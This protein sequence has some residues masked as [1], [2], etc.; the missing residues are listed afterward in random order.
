M[1]IIIDA[2]VYLALSALAFAVVA[3]LHRAVLGPVRNHAERVLFWSVWTAVSVLFAGAYHVAKGDLLF[4]RMLE[5][6]AL[7]IAFVVSIG[8]TIGATAVLSRRK[9]YDPMTDPAFLAEIE[10]RRRQR[11]ERWQAAI[12][13][14][15][16]TEIEHTDRR[17]LR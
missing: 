16:T 11:D 15:W 7:L 2:A 4:G 3:T 6:L 17:L 10:Q 13:T 1:T 5:M 9:P 12:G 8:S 14:T